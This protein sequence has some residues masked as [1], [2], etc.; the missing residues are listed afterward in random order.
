MIYYPEIL[1]GSDAFRDQQTAPRGTEQLAPTTYVPK[2]YICNA[3][4]V[5]E[6]TEV[7]LGV[8]ACGTLGVDV[9]LESQKP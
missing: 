7:R 3:F 4:G 1:S 9:C 2:H 8:E 5:H 6:H